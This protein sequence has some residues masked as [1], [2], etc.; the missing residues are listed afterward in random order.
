MKDCD[1]EMTEGKS[2]KVLPVSHKPLDH[3]Q[4]GARPKVHFNP[5]STRSMASLID[6]NMDNV[7]VPDSCD[8]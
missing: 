4:L 3:S 8:L 2:M 7:S 6:V 5:N 1:D